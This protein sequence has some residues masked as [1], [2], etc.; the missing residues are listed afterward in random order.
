MATGPAIGR[1]VNLRKSGQGIVRAY[2]VLLC[3]SEIFL[4]KPLMRQEAH[5]VFACD[6]AMTHS[7]IAWHSTELRSG[8]R[9]VGDNI[10]WLT[11]RKSLMAGRRSDRCLS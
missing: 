3:A 8:G 10:V 4:R 5:G 1:S 11:L 7:A 6:N 9:S 2:V